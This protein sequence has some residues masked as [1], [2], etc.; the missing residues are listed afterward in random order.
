MGSMILLLVCENVMFGQQGDVVGDGG[1]Q[2]LETTMGNGITKIKFK[3]FPWH[4]KITSFEFCP[5]SVFRI[6]ETDLIH[7]HGYWLAAEPTYSWR[8]IKSIDLWKERLSAHTHLCVM[9]HDGDQIIWSSGGNESSAIQVFGVMASEVRRGY[10]ITFEKKPYWG[11][12]SLFWA[13]ILLACAAVI[14]AFVTASCRAMPGHA[15]TD[16]FPEFLTIS[17]CVVGVSLLL[18]R[19]ANFAEGSLWIL[20]G[21]AA[22]GGTLDIMLNERHYITLNENR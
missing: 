6:T 1:R 17:V 16:R 12:W 11:P 20:A 3:Q 22:I 5:E 8:S 4:P 18:L 10:N 13:G 21:C 14:P 9:S 7:Y 2:S 15:A 19:I